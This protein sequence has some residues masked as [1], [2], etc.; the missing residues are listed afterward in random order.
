MHFFLYLPYHIEAIPK[1]EGVI[2]KLRD[3]F[4]GKSGGKINTFYPTL[5]YNGKEVSSKKLL[6]ND[7]HIGGE[8]VPLSQSPIR[9]KVFTCGF[10]QDNKKLKIIDY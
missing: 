10:T 6:H 8:G 2:N 5:S 1:K 3:H 7:E 4:K 9:L